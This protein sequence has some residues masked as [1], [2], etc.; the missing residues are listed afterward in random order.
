MTWACE[1]TE[2]AKEDFR[3]LPKAIQKRVS[4]VVTQMASDPFQGDVEALKAKSGMVSSA[5][6]LA[7]TACSLLSSVATG[8]LL[9]IRSRFDPA[10]PTDDVFRFGRV[11]FSRIRA[12]VKESHHVR[13]H[14]ILR[15]G[16]GRRCS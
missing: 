4:R 13:R 16:I 7:T 2:E 6:E 12:S 15:F 9:S 1:F 3:S 5:V 10:R 8:Q 14:L 11:P